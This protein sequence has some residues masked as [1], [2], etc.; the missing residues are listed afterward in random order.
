[1]RLGSPVTESNIARR[2]TLSRLA[3][4]WLNSPSIAVASGGTQV[5]TS[6][7]ISLSRSP[8]AALAR[9]SIAESIAEAVEA[10][11]RSAQAQHITA[12]RIAPTSALPAVWTDTPCAVVASVR[13]NATAPAHIANAIARLLSEKPSTELA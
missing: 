5:A 6:C 8:L 4:S 7:G 3:W 12:T 10:T 13:M 2:W 9:R 1:M 11:V